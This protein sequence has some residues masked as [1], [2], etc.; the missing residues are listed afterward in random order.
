[1]NHGEDPDHDVLYH[2]CQK[3]YGKK[4]WVVRVRAI[5]KLLNMME[6]LHMQRTSHK[7]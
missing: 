3:N 7:D 6:I 1:M 4:Q 2:T 5:R